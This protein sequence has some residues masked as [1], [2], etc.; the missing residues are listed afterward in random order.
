MLALRTPLKL[1]ISKTTG[2]SGSAADIKDIRWKNTSNTHQSGPA[3]VKQHGNLVI[4]VDNARA[5]DQAI[6]RS[7]SICG[8]LRPLAI[9]SPQTLQCYHCQQFHHNSQACP[10][11]HD[12]SKIRCARRAQP[13]ATKDCKCPS[14]DSPCSD[15]RSCRHLQAKCANYQGPHKSFDNGCPVKATCYGPN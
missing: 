14:S 4:T 10:D 13:H 3:A 1:S 7:L 2:S 6:Y 15:L 5:I 9:F 11:R 12:S 8:Q